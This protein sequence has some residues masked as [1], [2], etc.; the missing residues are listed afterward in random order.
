MRF[1]HVQ[2]AR[3]ARKSVG[4]RFN[5]AIGKNVADL[6]AE[7]LEMAADEDGAM[8]VE[9]LLL[10]A[11]DREAVRFCLFP[12]ANQAALEEFGARQQVVTDSAP[13]V[14]RWIMAAGAEFFAEENIDNAARAR[15]KRS[16][17]SRLKC[18]LCRLKGRDRT[19][20]IA[21]TPCCR[22]R[23]TNSSTVCVECPIVK[24]GSGIGNSQ[25]R[26]GV[27]RLGLDRRS[28]DRCYQLMTPFVYFKGQGEA[29]AKIN[30][31]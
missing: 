28:N 10:G 8:A 5:G 3:K 29:Q 23:P 20:P 21:V 11:H 13:L 16:I 6:Q 19:S 25:T 4:V 31:S 26:R 22:S 14:T 18:G 27:W 7:R 2:L 17:S 30:L 1:G 24:T 9:R 12:H 15:R